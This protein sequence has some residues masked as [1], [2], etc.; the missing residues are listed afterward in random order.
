MRCVRMSVDP[1]LL[2]EPGL[3]RSVT[4]DTFTP[5]KTISIKELHARTGHWVRTAK[6]TPLIVTDRGEKIATL[7]PHV[8]TSGTPAVINLAARLKWM[9]VSRADSTVFISEDRDGR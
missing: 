1:N 2:A 6:T 8:P 9:P 7:Q 5:V 4:G 3:D